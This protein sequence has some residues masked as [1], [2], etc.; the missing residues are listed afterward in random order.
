M[1]RAKKIVVDLPSALPVPPAV[2]KDVHSL[3]PL[4]PFEMPPKRKRGRPP[5]SGKAAKI[6]KT[7]PLPGEKRG[8]GRPP[9]STNA[10]KDIPPSTIGIDFPMIASTHFVPTDENDILVANQK[11]LLVQQGVV[12]FGKNITI[13][14]FRPNETVKMLSTWSNCI[15]LNVLCS[16]HVATTLAGIVA[17]FPVCV[18][19]GDMGKDGRHTCY[20]CIAIH[21][22][23][24]RALCCRVYP[25]LS[26]LITA[27]TLLNETAEF[28]SFFDVRD[29]SVLTDFTGVEP[30][31][32]RSAFILISARWL[33]MM[34]Y[35]TV[36]TKLQRVHI[37]DLFAFKS[38]NFSHIQNK[39]KLQDDHHIWGGCEYPPSVFEMIGLG[40]P[41]DTSKS[42]RCRAAVANQVRVGGKGGRLWCPSP[43]AEP[44]VYNDYDSFCF[45]V[46]C[47]DNQLQYLCSAHNYLVSPSAEILCDTLQFR[48]VFHLSGLIHREAGDHQVLARSQC[49]EKGIYNDQFTAT[50][51]VK[52]VQEITNARATSGKNLSTYFS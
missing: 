50:P 5:G 31:S 4:P 41:T 48:Q 26:H 44:V 27:T 20:P 38:A 17:V 3:P 37:A 13:P 16:E 43:A 1:Q 8:P 11:Y 35:F 6:P 18:Y 52:I 40:S 39:F 9:G 32:N 46:E 24:F 47:W 42:T 21:V 14:S 51:M 2:P 34:K 10:R 23:Q 30:I 49:I 25:A 19:N 22:E 36:D 29:N 33:D 15:M 28:A 45:G 7:I 12:P